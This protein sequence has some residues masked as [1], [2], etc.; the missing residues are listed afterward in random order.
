MLRLFLIVTLLASPIAAKNVER[1]RLNYRRST[2]TTTAPAVEDNDS[3][4]IKYNDNG[5]DGFYKPGDS[6]TINGGQSTYPNGDGNG[7]ENSF[8]PITINGDKIKAFSEYTIGSTKYS[9]PSDFDS[10][11]KYGYGLKNH[12]AVTTNTNSFKPSSNLDFLSSDYRIPNQDTKQKASATN[13]FSVYHPIPTKPTLTGSSL[14]DGKVK[15]LSYNF[16]DDYDLGTTTTKYKKNKLSTDDDSFGESTSYGV[17]HS[18]GVGKPERG[19]HNGGKKKSSYNFGE[20]PHSPLKN[21]G[22]GVVG[23]NDKTSS[24]IYDTDSEES[25]FGSAKFKP[26]A[27]GNGYSNSFIIDVNDDSSESFAKPKIPKLHS[28]FDASPTNPLAQYDSDFDVKNIKLPGIQTKNRPP[29]FTIQSQLR[30]KQQGSD[31]D[32]PNPLEFRPNFKLQDVPNLYPDEHLGSGA[33]SKTQLENFLHAEQAFVDDAIR[34]HYQDGGNPPPKKGHHQQFL[35]QQE[36]DHLE[37]EALKAQIE[38]LKAQAAKRPAEFKQRPP[39][40]QNPYNGFPQNPNQPHIQGPQN[41]GHHNPQG[42]Q[43]PH[44]L[45]PNSQ[46]PHSLGPQHLGPG[47]FGHRNHGPPGP[48]GPRGR[49]VRRTPPLTAQLKATLPLARVPHFNERAYSISFKV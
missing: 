14:F 25:G 1:R 44:N 6:H 18:Y 5:N 30:S 36:D 40:G 31:I 38:F 10:E 9:D 27:K 48:L 26:F 21:Y 43:I 49:P 13:K 4:E 34:T 33:V 19:F 46:G 39:G 3:S 15:K 12:K 42:P 24:T 35:K 41:F 17:G 47:N 11:E 8:K 7:K 28:S 23:K 16:P 37:K 20:P 2:T 29:A 32:N 45:G 22:D